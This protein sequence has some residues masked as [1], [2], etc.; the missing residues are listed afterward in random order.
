MNNRI[1]KFLAIA[2]FLLNISQIV[3]GEAV[4]AVTGATPVKLKIE[5]NVDK[6][7]VLDVSY[8][9]NSVIREAPLGLNVDHRLLGKDAQQLSKEKKENNTLVYE[10]QQVDGSRF[11]L[12]AR[13]FPD[14]IALR[15]R[16]PADGPVCIYGEETSF[17]FPSQTKAWYASGPFQYGWLQEYQERETDHIEGELLAPPATFRL[18][19]GIYAAITEANLFNYH[20]AVLLGTAPNCVRFGYVENK[21]HVETGIVTGLPPTKYWHEEVRDIPWIVSPKEGEPGNCYSLACPYAGKRFE[22]PGE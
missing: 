1:T 10:F 17:I 22:R 18:P 21:G 8:E 12:D 20:G 4:D 6:Q 11:F 15:Y 7:L 3:K 19:N 16:V 5:A 13:I 14:G 9:E 2:L